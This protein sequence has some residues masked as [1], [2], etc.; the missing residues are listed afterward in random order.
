MRHQRAVHGPFKPAACT[1]CH[2]VFASKPKMYQHMQ[3][4]G[5]KRHVCTQCGLK[6]HMKKNLKSHCE[7][8]H[9]EQRRFVCDLCGHRVSS[10]KSLAAHSTRCGKPGQNNRRH[11]TM[12]APALESIRPYLWCVQC[13]FRCRRP[14]TLKRHYSEQHPSE[15]WDALAQCL[16]KRCIR[17]FDTTELLAEHLAKHHPTV[18]CNICKAV[19]LCELTLERHKKIH[20]VKERPFKCAVREYFVPIVMWVVLKL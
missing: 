18:Q 3:R 5:E 2:K 1:V 16:C 6:F 13:D 4:H 10:K 7:L 14:G 11:C 8:V 17:Q 19:L 9:E 12:A 20:T 15:D